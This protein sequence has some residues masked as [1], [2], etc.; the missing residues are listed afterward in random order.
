MN[1]DPLTTIGT[2]RQRQRRLVPQWWRNHKEWGANIGSGL[3]ARLF[4][5]SPPQLLA[6]R[7]PLIEKSRLQQQ[8]Q[9][10]GVLACRSI[11]ERAGK[12]EQDFTWATNPEDFVQPGH[13]VL[14]STVQFRFSRSTG[15]LWIDDFKW[16]RASNPQNLMDH[17]DFQ[18]I[19]LRKDWLRRL[20]SDLLDGLNS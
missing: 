4:L 8:W 2:M 15:L 10:V 5:Y 17:L 19:L 20:H 7:Q 9:R 16:T 11:D 14:Q 3:L 6:P 18:G 12:I 1:G 13:T